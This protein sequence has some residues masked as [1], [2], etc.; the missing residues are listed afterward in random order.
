MVYEHILKTVVLPSLIHS[1]RVIPD[2]VQFDNPDLVILYGEE[3]A[4]FDSLNLVNFIFI[5]EEK[6]ET[7]LK[8]SFKFTTEDILNTDSKPFLNAQ[9]LATFLEKRFAETK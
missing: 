1:S 6:I 3:G 9:S 8:I 5:V 2:I 4:I 7:E